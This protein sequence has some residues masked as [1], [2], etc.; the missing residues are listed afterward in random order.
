MFPESSPEPLQDNDRVT[1]PPP[2]IPPGKS[3]RRFS[4]EISFVLFLTAIVF[5]AFVGGA[6]A[7]IAGVSPTNYLRDAYNA[8][9]A[10]YDKLVNYQDPLASDLWAHARTTR[11]GV[12]VYEPQAACNGLTLYTSGHAAKAFLIDMQGQILHQWHRE[13]STVWDRSAAVRQPAPDERVNICKARVFPNG[14]LLAIYIG[15]G[16]TPYGYGMVKLDRDS[17]IIWKN[18][19]YFHHDFD[20]DGDGRIY[21]LT[22]DFRSQLPEQLDFLTA[23]ILEDFLVVVSPEGQTLKKIPLLDAIDRSGF[24][25]LLWL[26]PYYSLADPLHTN[27]VDVLDEQDA[28]RLR[29][30]VPQAAAGQ[31][32]LSFRELAGGTIALL[33]VNKETIVWAM[34]GPW[35]SQHDPDI[36]ADGNLLMFDNRGNFGHNGESRV[37]EVDPGSGKVVWHYSGSSGHFFQSMI[38]GDQERLPNGDTLITESDGGRLL[39]VTFAGRIA[40]EFINPVR[41]GKQ[42]RLIPVVNWA[43]RIAPGYL[44]ADVLDGFRKQMSAEEDHLP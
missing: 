25:R 42:D 11:R 20:I 39:E 41:G 14:D 37:I 7:T 44:K 24:R 2:V 23:P 17:N 12:T 27:A 6:I 4:L 29:R 35:M 15:V 28:G 30:K 8:G 21:G 22:H 5:L 36:L 43:E 13:Y 19:N 9:T 33:D 3:E 1:S 26:V 34:R 18:L 32:L 16:D 40:W 31:V 38:R 10:Y